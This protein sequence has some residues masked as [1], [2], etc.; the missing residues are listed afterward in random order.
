MI[1]KVKKSVIQMEYNLQLNLLFFCDFQKINFFVD[2]RYLDSKFR[3]KKHYIGPVF[4]LLK[5]IIM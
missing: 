4:S 3:R 1:L 2:T 5:G